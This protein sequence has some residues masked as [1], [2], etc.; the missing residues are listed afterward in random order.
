MRV[1]LNGEV[2]EIAQQTTVEELLCSLHLERTP[3]AVERNTKIIPRAKY[4]T[5]VLQPDD[6]VEI[7]HFVGGG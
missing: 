2:H 4:S 1:L 7:V 5:A 6:E 3:V